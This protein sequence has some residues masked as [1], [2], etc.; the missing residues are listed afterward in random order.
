M[1]CLF[2]HASAVQ[3]VKCSLLIQ[4]NIHNPDLFLSALKKHWNLP[5]LLLF[6]PFFDCTFKQ[7]ECTGLGARA[8]LYGPCIVAVL[9][10]VCFVLKG[11][12]SSMWWG[13]VVT[14]K[15]FLSRQFKS[16]LTIIP[17]SSCCTLLA[18]SCVYKLYI[19]FFSKKSSSCIL[20]C[21][22]KEDESSAPYQFHMVFWY[23]FKI[24][25]KAEFFSLQYKQKCW[26]IP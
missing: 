5:L 19:F 11:F 26:F 22:N 13:H 8:M 16:I 7:K 24:H 18:Y 9:S 25:Q 4:L 17:L 23:F 2:A 14:H 10:V 15:I 21:W 1:A 12:L 20:G 6:V 3:S